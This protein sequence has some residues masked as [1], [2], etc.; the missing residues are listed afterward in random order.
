MPSGPG[1]PADTAPHE[2]LRISGRSLAAAVAALGL[3]IALAAMF[4]ASVRVLGWLLAS[5][6]VAALLSPLVTALAKRMRRGFALALV[7]GGLAAAVGMVVYGLVDDVRVELQRVQREAPLLAQRLEDSERWGDVARDFELVEKV[8]RF[9]DELPSRLQGGD[10]AAAL[11]SNAT[12][13]VAY[14]ASFI[15]M[16]FLLSHGRRLVQATLRQVHDPRRRVRLAGAAI[17]VYRRWWVYVAGRVAL[18]VAAGVVANLTA[19]VAGLPGPR[20]MGVFMFAT[21]LVPMVGVLAGSVPLVAFAAG[22]H[23]M[24]TAFFVF[25]LACAY[26]VADIVACR[27]WVERRSVTVGPVVTLV[28]GMFGFELYGVGGAVVAVALG[29]FA[30]AVVDELAPDD[31]DVVAL[32]AF[33]NS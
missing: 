29:A 14:L 10:A 11:R 15:L 24:R 21:S 2:R 28:S 30:V 17:S 31:S 22:F 32:D 26:Q 3:A 13:F 27:R 33:T 16:L 6:L 12:R 25:V 20:V 5:S 4:R 18:S 9:V 1:M 23:D 8:Q 19:R 7:V